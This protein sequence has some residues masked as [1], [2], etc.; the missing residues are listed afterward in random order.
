MELQSLHGLFRNK[1]TKIV[2]FS[3]YF[4]SY[5]YLDTSPTLFV[6]IHLHIEECLK[7][8]L[9]FAILSRNPLLANTCIAI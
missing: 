4:Y 5:I 6:D 2:D 7:W 3:A 1:Y 9:R 8:Q